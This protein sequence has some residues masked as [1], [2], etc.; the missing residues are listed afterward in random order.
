MKKLLLILA[1]TFTSVSA[2]AAFYKVNITRKSQDLY[3][4]ES[5]LYI[6]TRYCYEYPYGNDAVLKY[7][8]YGYNNKLIFDNGS[9]CEVEKV[10]G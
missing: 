3:K 8:P 6:V 1:F 5:G 2:F 9:T 10:L 7:E 4:T